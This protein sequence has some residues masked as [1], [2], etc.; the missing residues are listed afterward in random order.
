[1]KYI[2]GCFLLVLASY[3]VSSEHSR[4]P[5]LEQGEG[6]YS[7]QL[8]SGVSVKNI[9]IFYYLPKKFNEE[10]SVII[11]IP[12]AGR[13]AN[14]YR[15]SWISNAEKYNLLVLSPSYPKKDF[16][17]AAYHLGGVVNQLELKDPE[18]ERVN[19]RITKYRMNDENLSFSFVKDTNQWI[20]D[21][22]DKIFSSVKPML[23]A[24]KTS[25]D[26]FGHSAGGQLLH[27]YAIFKK[28]TNANRIVAANSGFYTLPDQD[29]AFPFGLSGTS[30]VEK[31]M[32]QAFTNRL[33]LLLGEFDN[34]SETR[35]TMLHTP[36]SDSQGLG[37]Y[38][39]GLYFFNKSQEIAKSSSF[40]FNWQQVTVPGVGHDYRKMG[41]AAAKLLY[42][43]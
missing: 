4:T 15:D 26:L 16:D 10:T 2:V 43:E 31:D 18:I 22:F 7:I 30:V 5:K 41:D 11:V 33:I 38:E 27:R 36:K 32:G 8:G 37:R 20:F 23:G 3:G 17:F 14:D 13:N 25:Y 9:D 42:Q 35:G 24:K 39:R 40:E 21:D 6:S 19:G 1:M 28:G 29:T 34:A 12:G